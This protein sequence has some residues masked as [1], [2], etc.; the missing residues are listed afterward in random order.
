MNFLIRP[1]HRIVQ[2]FLRIGIYGGPGVGKTWLAGS[3]SEWEGGGDC[4]YLDVEA[5][6]RT[7]RQFPSM[8]CIPITKWNQMSAIYGFISEHIRRRDSENSTQQLIDLE[9]RVTRKKPT[10]PRR[11]RTII[12]D[13][14]S[15]LDKLCMDGILNSTDD[16]FED[17]EVFEA[18]EDAQFKQYK[19]NFN[20]MSK[21]FRKFRNLDCNIIMCARE[22]DRSTFNPPPRGPAF[23]P[24]LT[25]KLSRLLSHDLDLIGRLTFED[26][27]VKRTKPDGEVKKEVVQRRV[28]TI[29]PNKKC[30]AKNRFATNATFILSPTMEK[31]AKVASEG[32][33]VDPD[34][35]ESQMPVED[36]DQEPSQPDVEK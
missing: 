2:D 30:I 20:K 13:S 12:I 16:I 11:I 8:W 26:V 1:S 35:E 10:E 15:E 33:K 22:I 29:A 25:G 23:A 3:A 36:N 28:L 7:L 21:L 4:L 32:L 14:I 19:R 27:T 9:Y 24:E 31:I 6:D 34:E 18:E 17:T 5:G